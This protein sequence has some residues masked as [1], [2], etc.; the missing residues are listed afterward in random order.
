MIYDNELTI[1]A[2]DNVD[3]LIPWLLCLIE[4]QEKEQCLHLTS[5]FIISENLAVATLFILSFVGIEA[6]F[7][8]CRWEIFG[9]WWSLIRRPR[10]KR[11]NSSV[12]NFMVHQAQQQEQKTPV[13]EKMPRE[14]ATAVDDTNAAR[15]GRDNTAAGV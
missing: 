1:E 6:F 13:E 10:W 3:K 14:D 11:N 8:L 9:A 4:T 15:G 2:F 12:S 5:P 7:L